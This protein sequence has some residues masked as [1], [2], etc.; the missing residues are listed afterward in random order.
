ME[1][2]INYKTRYNTF[3]KLIVMTGDLVM[4][5]IWFWLFY[6]FSGQKV[7]F[8][9]I[10]TLIVI[11]VVYVACTLKG[12]S[13]LYMR[14]VRFHRIIIRVLN[15]ICI[16]SV[17]STF[18]L[19]IGHFYMPNW[20]LYSAYLFVL[21][22]SLSFFRLSIYYLVKGYRLQ[23]KHIRYVVLVGSTENNIALYHELADNVSLGYQVCGYFDDE[24]NDIYPAVCP[25]LGTPDDVVSYLK[26]HDNIRGLY[27]CLPSVRKA[28]ILSIIHYCENHFIWFYSVPNIRN[29]LLRRMHLNTIGTVPYLSL[30]E[31]PLSLF[32]NRAIKRIF[33]ILF[34]LIFL[35]TLFPFVLVIVTLITKIT[36]PGPIFFMQK[37]NG[38]NGKE[39]TCLKF[40][41]MKLNVDA[42][43]RQATKND[44]RVTHWGNIM[45]SSNIDELPQ[46]VN[47]FLGSMSVVGPRP[48]MLKHTEEYS[49][50]INRYMMRHLVKP[51]ITGWSQMMGF[52]GETKELSQMEGRVKGDIWY[53]E[54]WNFWLDLYIIYKTIV[55]TL[56]GEKNAY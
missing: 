53:V 12:N 55:N 9:F 50:R 40:R 7:D 15:I 21:C 52:R 3:A 6:L 24:P 18:L 39:F 10:Q 34:S 8:H 43:E 22:L 48:H 30:Y 41:S 45:R 4:C 1:N 23:K 42:D 36:M 54:H 17:V 33:D 32:E 29:Y 25:W 14:Q 44:P 19:Y 2:K 27:C 26:E 37:R 46:F 49:H 56:H 13:D 31:E 38:L 35:C 20:R 11:S 47:V 5:D 16:Y 51:G 28:E